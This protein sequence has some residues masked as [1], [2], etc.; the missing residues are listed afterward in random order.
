MNVTRKIGRFRKIETLAHCDVCPLA[1]QIRLPFQSSSS[2][3]S[4]CFDLIHIDV[5]GPS[6][7]ATYDDIKIFLILVDDHSR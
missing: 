2:R 1:R 4:K 6:K 3:S 5:W 7:T